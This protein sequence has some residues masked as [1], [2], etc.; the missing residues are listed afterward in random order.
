MKPEIKATFD[1]FC[2]FLPI[3]V[4]EKDDEVWLNVETHPDF[5]E[6]AYGGPYPNEDL[7]LLSVLFYATGVLFG[8]ELAQEGEMEA[9]IEA[10]L[11]YFFNQLNEVCDEEDNDGE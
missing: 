1:Y 6:L 4:E 11:T 8:I 9:E 3:T 10:R 5:S 7:A 2:S